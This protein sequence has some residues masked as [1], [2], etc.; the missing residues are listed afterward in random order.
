[1]REMKRQLADKAEMERN[2]EMAATLQKKESMLRDDAQRKAEAAKRSAVEKELI[3]QNR[4]LAYEREQA[5]KDAVRDASRS[6]RACGTPLY[7][8]RDPLTPPTP[9]ARTH[10]PHFPPCACAGEASAHLRAP[11][12]ARGCGRRADGALRGREAAARRGRGG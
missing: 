3:R 9:S 6:A 2:R 1:M 8:A 7:R 5:E 10:S 4:Q 11:E 12:A